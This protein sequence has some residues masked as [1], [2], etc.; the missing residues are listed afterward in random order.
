MQR[1]LHIFANYQRSAMRTKTPE[2]IPEIYGYEAE[3]KTIS[4]LLANILSIPFLLLYGGISGFAYF[5]VW[6]SF[7]W[8]SVANALWLLVAIVVGIV[9]HELVHGLTWLV[10]TR[11]SFSH[12]AFG[13]MAGA[14][15]CHIDVPMRKRPYII[16]AVMPLLLMGILPTVIAIAIGS[17]FWLV[18]G[19]IFTVCAIGDIMIMWKIRREPAD[20]LIYDHPTEG[21]CIVYRRVEEGDS[22]IG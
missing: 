5:K 17:A 22:K 2:P 16:G 15:Y 12:L 19:V 10:V 6:H 3:T 20:T 7:E 21:G 4:I 11:K 9:V 14:A 13:L 1:E 8:S 18:F